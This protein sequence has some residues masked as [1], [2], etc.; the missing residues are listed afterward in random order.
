M[1]HLQPWPGRA[2]PVVGPHGVHP[3]GYA[4]ETHIEHMF[5]II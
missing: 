1:Q 4:I 5:F 2:T 3:H